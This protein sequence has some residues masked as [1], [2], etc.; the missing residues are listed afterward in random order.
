MGKLLKIWGLDL[1]RKINPGGKPTLIQKILKTL[2]GRANLL[3]RTNVNRPLQAISGDI[4]EIRFADGHGKAYLSVHKDVFGQ[5]VYGWKLGLTME[6]TLVKRSFNMAVKRIKR[7]TQPIQRRHP[8]KL[9][10]LLKNILYHQDR[11]SQYTSYQ[12]VEMAL[13][14]G[15]LSYSDPGTPTH[16]PGQESFFGRFKTEWGDEM[17]EIKTFEE[18]ERFVKHK[19]NYYNYSRRH[20]SIGLISPSKF[21]KTFVKKQSKRYSKFST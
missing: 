12:Y 13:T 3:I 14:H 21:T 15:R 9:K 19:I 17:L 4:T 16:N 20:T 6:T 7:L 1:K 18:L 2:A 5:V 11:G 8:E 10:Q